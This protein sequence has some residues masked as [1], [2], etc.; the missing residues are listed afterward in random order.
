MAAAASPTENRPA[1]EALRLLDAV[2][3]VAVTVA[4]VFLVVLAVRAMARLNPTFTASNRQTVALTATLGIYLAFAAGLGLALRRFRHPLA[5]LGVRWPAPREVLLVVVGMV[6]WF[7]SIAAVSIGVAAIFNR[8]QPVPSNTRQLFIQVPHGPALLLYALL[9]SAV[10]APICE[11]IF[12]RGMI[13]RYLR[14]RW[15]L[16]AAALVSAII[17]G[18]AHLSPATSPLIVPVLAF[19]GLVLALVYE[20]TGS[21]TNSM[22]LHA[23]N[24]GVLTTV[25]YFVI[26]R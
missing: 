8:G 14:A 15:P 1:G 7:L 24:N 19:I 4:G 20:R 18:A 12:F 17:F 16:W 25:T 23:L 6:P 13:F 22:M 21:L 9:V 11:E 3:V 2:P 26:T 5:M 10:A